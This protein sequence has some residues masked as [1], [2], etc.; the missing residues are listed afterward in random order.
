MPLIAFLVVFGVGEVIETLLSQIVLIKVDFPTDGRPI[1]AVVAHFVMAE[2]ITVWSEK[3]NA[4][5]LCGVFISMKK[6][7]VVFLVSSFLFTSCPVDLSLSEKEDSIVICSWNVQNLFDGVDNGNEYEEFLTSSGWNDK[8]YR[9]RLAKIET[10]FGYG[11]LSSASI[12]VLNEVENEGVVQDILSLSSFKKR[13]FSYF[14]CAGEEGGAIRIAVISRYPI[15]SAFV[16]SSVGMRP[17]LEVNFNFSG[18]RLCVLAVHA[19]SNLGDQEENISLRAKTGEIIGGVASSVQSEDP[20]AVI[21]VAGDY[22]ECAG[23][24]NVLRGDQSWYVFWEDQS[25]S[26]S[27]PG[28]YRYNGQWFTY[29]NIALSRAAV[30]AGV[31]SGGILSTIYGYPDSFSSRLLSGVSDHFPVW[32]RLEL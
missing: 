23:D 31:E 27:A 12:V 29:D 21:A 20:G 11:E 5:P 19:K 2:S 32:V 10:V 24:G 16:H 22:N 18:Q 28:S 30:D 1:T 15:V 7:F 14:A 13:G 4:W 17:V 25:L 8:Q 9:V 3:N 26:L 6:I